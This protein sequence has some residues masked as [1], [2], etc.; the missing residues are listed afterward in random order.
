MYKSYKIIGTN[1]DL[2]CLM[3]PAYRQSID[4]C[5]KQF[6]LIKANQFKKVLMYLLIK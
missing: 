4:Q 5:V 2:F 3:R 1:D 6:S